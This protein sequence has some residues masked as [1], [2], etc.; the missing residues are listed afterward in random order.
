[1]IDWPA[2]TA[3]IAG[4]YTGLADTAGNTLRASHDV[5]PDAIV[6]P[7]AVSI[8]RGLQEVAVYAGWMTG[9]ATVDV[10][11]LVE[12]IADLPRRTAAILAWVG[13]AVVATLGNVQLSLPA[14]VA[15]AVPGEAVVEM[16]GESE[17]YAGLAYDMVRVPITVE[18]RQQVAVA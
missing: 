9:K 16:A 2:L 5:L 8:F 14:N 15:S 4:R 13:P 3:T 18:F 17:V 12:P 10:L 7:C 6:A 11:I 1:M